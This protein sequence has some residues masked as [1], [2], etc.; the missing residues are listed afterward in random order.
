MSVSVTSSRSCCL[1]ELLC[2]FQLPLPDPLGGRL[3]RVGVAHSRS[4]AGYDGD[5]PNSE[6][7][8]YDGHTDRDSWSYA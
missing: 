2:L 7:R 6:H 1:L 5:H 8:Q 4:V 3:S